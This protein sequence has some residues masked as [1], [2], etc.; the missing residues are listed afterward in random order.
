LDNDGVEPEADPPGTDDDNAETTELG[1]N[2]FVLVL[3]DERLDELV[4][5]VDAI[6]R[7]ASRGAR[8]VGV[9]PP[10]GIEHAMPEMIDRYGS[11]T[12]ACELGHLRRALVDGEGEA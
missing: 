8:V 12:V 6:R 5:D 1:P 10:E 3:L 9:W 11:V 2:D 7:C 4:A